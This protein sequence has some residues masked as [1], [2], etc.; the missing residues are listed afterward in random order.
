MQTFG[1]LFY[2]EV[3]L[4]MK[5]KNI[6]LKCP[7]C[8]S[9]VQLKS[10][11]GIYKDNS[12]GAMLYICSNYPECDAYVRTCA[13]TN[14]P[15][16]TMANSALHRLRILAHKNFDII[17]KNCIMSK[18]DLYLWLANLLNVP[19]SQAHISFLGE[20]YCR[21]VIDESQKI[22]FSLGV[23]PRHSLAIFILL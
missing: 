14:I 3:S 8:G 2:Q 6:P 16:G 5:K 19:L 22:Q 20:Y 12:K 13:G 10:A 15:A 23:T 18:R 11:D 7:Y 17:C 21:L 4:A 9:R 1:F